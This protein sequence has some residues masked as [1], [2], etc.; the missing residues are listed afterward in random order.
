LPPTPINSPDL[1]AINAAAHPAHTRYLYF[2]NKVCGNGRLLFTASYN[3]FL[4][5]SALWNAAIATAAKNH[6]NAEFCKGG[7][8]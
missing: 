4:H 7:K 5:W 2:I 6:G 3:Q 1:P 8:P